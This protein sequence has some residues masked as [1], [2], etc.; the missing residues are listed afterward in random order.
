LAGLVQIR[1]ILTG[2]NTNAASGSNSAP[3]LGAGTATGPAASDAGTGSGGTPAAG[4]EV[5]TGA[6][7]LS[8]L[9]DADVLASITA[10]ETIAHMAQAQQAILTAHLTAT[11]TAVR[12]AKKKSVRG[13]R[14]EV[15]RDI[16]LHRGSNAT[17]AQKVVD[18][19]NQAPD[20]C[21]GLFE[22]WIHGEVSEDQVVI[23]FDETHLL[24]PDGRRAADEDVADLAPM[25]GLKELRHR[26]R[27]ITARL[28][29]E[30]AA[31]RARKALEDRHVSSRC[32]GDSMMKLN[33][34]LP[35][36]AGQGVD[37]ILTGYA[38]KRRAAGDERTEAQIKADALTGIVI[39]W[40][41]ATHNTPK[42]FAATHQIKTHGATPPDGPDISDLPTP[43]D[44]SGNDQLPGL[45]VP[46]F[47]DEPPGFTEVGQARAAF[48]EFLRNPAGTA[49]GTASPGGTAVKVGDSIDAESPI[50]GHP[51]TG[52][53]VLPP[54]VG[55]QVNLVITDF[56]AF[57]ITDNPAEIF[58]LG[59]LPAPLARQLIDDAVAKHAAT[60]KKLYTDP[61]SGALVGMESRSRV[62]P[63]QLGQLIA[64]RDQHCRHPYCDSP[65]K[66]LD[67]I[68][69][70]AHGGPTSFSNGQGLCARHNLIKDTN[71]TTH[72]ATI[73]GTGDGTA[74]TGDIVTRLSASG[75][76]FTSPARDFP[77]ENPDTLDSQHYWA[78]YRDGKNHTETALKDTSEA[79]QAQNE[80]NY[81]RI[82][83]LT[84]IKSYLADEYEEM[85]QS[86]QDQNRINDILDRRI[87][88]LAA[89]ETDLTEKEAAVTRQAEEQSEAIANWRRIAPHLDEDF[90]TAIDYFIST[91]HHFDVGFYPTSNSYPNAA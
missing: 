68:H 33:A 69:P 88:K 10:L 76:E 77:H 87:R 82:D 84:R 21:P 32:R 26:L 14:V 30:L 34:L 24:I 61:A 19:A 9:A 11:R 58:G 1:N 15:A 35:G 74:G 29:P 89:R 55:V 80:A 39:G 7:V 37:T 86:Q 62:F 31:E 51:P 52:T 63:D 36:I 28:E 20:E 71:A 67:H 53:G 4:A 27:T 46:D 40:A 54:G 18:A 73:D 59:P 78:G 8:G 60:H 44:G 56:S 17:R 13:V 70:H 72:P 3:G 66:H 50:T 85:C 12:E 65:I 48:E 79:V 45:D 6:D 49:A 22:H 81:D 57:G 75:A 41:R 90:F 43:V 5:T 25:I 83:V 47:K 23:F 2:L 42:S 64:F 16:T 91:G 38:K